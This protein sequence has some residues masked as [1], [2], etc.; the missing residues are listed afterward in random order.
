[1]RI[2]L[3]GFLLLA[4]LAGA[5]SGAE[6]SRI[7]ELENAWNQAVQQKDIRA[8]APLMGNELVYIDYDGTMMNKAEYLASLQA[9]ALHLEHIVSDSMQVQFFGQSAVVMGVYTEKGAKNGKPYLRRERFIDTWI[10]QEGLWVC[11]ASQSTLIL[12]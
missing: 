10:R 7:R 5:Q 4:L 8:I 1:M 12:H 6:Q 3:C 9:P 11:V 2:G